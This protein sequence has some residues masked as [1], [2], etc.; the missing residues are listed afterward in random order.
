[1]FQI[2][3][4]S[5]ARRDVD[6]IFDWIE[7]RS[8]AGAERWY[9]AFQAAWKTLR[10]DPHRHPIASEARNV[11]NEFREFY[12]RTKH[13]KRYRLLFT[14]DDSQVVIYRVRGPG[15]PPVRKG[16]LK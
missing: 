5:D 2:V 8:P 6:T 1:M 16:D 13:G 15:E 14:I 3:I 12:F 9:E 10:T 7:E 11:G 4:L